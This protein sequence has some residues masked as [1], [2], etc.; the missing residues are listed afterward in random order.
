MTRPDNANH[1]RR[2]LLTHPLSWLLAAAALLG[3]FR[4][5][6]VPDGSNLDEAA[7]FTPILILRSAIVSCIQHQPC[8]IPIANLQPGG[9]GPYQG[10]AYYLLQAVAQ[11]FLPDTIGMSTRLLVAR[12]LT[13]CL[14]IL[15]IAL[16]YGSVLELFPSRRIWALASAAL[17]A[18]I[19]SFGD[20]MSGVNLDAPAAALGTTII[21]TFARIIGRGPNLLRVGALVAEFA[22][23][24]LLKGTVWPLAG[25][26]LVLF[27]W[28]LP[29]MYRNIAVGLAAAGG[30][31]AVVAF[32]PIEWQRTAYWFVARSLRD[33]REP[34]LLERVSTSHV[35]GTYS[36][37]AGPGA[38]WIGQ[39]LPESWV[40]QL[41][42]KTV[43][44]GVWYRSLDDATQVFAPL[45]GSGE[46]VSKDVL[47]ADADWRF[48]AASAKVPGDAMH[49][50]FNLSRP[51][52]API[53]YDG[54]VLVEGEFPAGQ[55]PHYLDAD[56]I[57]GT[58][59]GRPFRNLLQNPSA[60]TTWPQIQLQYDIVY[61]LNNRIVSV[62]Y[63]QRAW[64]AWIDLSRWMV[65]NLWSSFGGVL[66]GLNRLQMIPF[67]FLTA[68]AISGL[69]A[70]S[71]RDL[72]A[73]A[74]FFADARSR[75]GL[76]MLVA[77]SSLALLIVVF[78][79]DIIVYESRILLWSSMRHASAE[80]AAL[81]ALLSIGLLR[82]VPR[83]HHRMAVACA[84]V[85]LFCTSIYILLRVQY[86]FQHCIL[87]VATD[88]LISIR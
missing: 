51:S 56:G 21:F 52:T 59:G 60:E 34:L 44:F 10:L 82:W 85:M 61:S 46:G 41:R 4:I 45:L 12:L 35:V 53:L 27:W 31:M 43:T 23:G 73:R 69:M 67:A 6:V 63:W 22:L 55:Q 32:Q 87:P 86:P 70:I 49:L 24:Y 72:P 17:A 54:A 13:L 88:C 3:I 42:G 18:F 7:H 1:P 48:Y 80:R 8:S 39:Y 29:A 40:V 26:A 28:K 14:N 66:P 5:L 64:P 77:V 75:A 62:L 19:P 76:L 33:I 57:A 71:L 50:A 30:L 25:I 78:R 16:T 83:Q 2:R 36:M 84:I 9:S 65:V 68:L 79:A 81:C 58:W 37:Q 20:M 38:Y 11:S 74:G 47:V 15:V